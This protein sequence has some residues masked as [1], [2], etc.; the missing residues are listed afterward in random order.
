MVEQTQED[1]VIDKQADRL[2]TEIN[3]AVDK[4]IAEKKFIEARRILHKI[5]WKVRGLDKKCG[6]EYSKEYLAKHYPDMYKVL[7]SSLGNYIRF[8]DDLYY[9]KNSKHNRMYLRSVDLIAGSPTGDYIELKGRIDDDNSSVSFKL[10]HCMATH[11]RFVKSRAK[12]ELLAEMR[13]KMPPSDDLAYVE[14]N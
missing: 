11:V 7:M 10:S 12:P 3:A 14:W 4:L 1:I 13:N 2:M 5:E 6:K 8:Y 9:T